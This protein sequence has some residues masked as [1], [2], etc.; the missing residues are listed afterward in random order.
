MKEKQVFQYAPPNVSQPNDS[1]GP[2]NYDN[3]WVT[4]TTYHHLTTSSIQL[5]AFG[6]SAE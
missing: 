2:I 4:N 3:W 5:T 6:S 1:A